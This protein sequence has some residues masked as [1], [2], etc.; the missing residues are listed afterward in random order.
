MTQS[1]KLFATDMDGTFLND[2][3]EYDQAK[4]SELYQEMKA[5]NIRF[6][7]ASDN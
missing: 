2:Q 1:Y 7:V 3:M 4:F 5:N 6:V